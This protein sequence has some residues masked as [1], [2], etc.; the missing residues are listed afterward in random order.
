MTDRE[1]PQ[2]GEYASPQEQAKARAR[3]GAEPGPPVTA[4]PPSSAA[5]PSSGNG[6]A[7]P[8]AGTVDRLLTVFLLAFGLVYLLSGTASYLDLAV[9]MEAVYAQFGI[10]DYTPQPQT[11]AIGIAIVAGQAVIW[12]VS[13]VWAYRRLRAGRMAWWVPVLGAVVT[14]VVSVILLGTLLLG[15]PAFLENVTRA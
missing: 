12:L 4:R 1:R 6:R 13:A 11:Q 14:F 15:D 10:G 8:L 3:S 7:R 9:A 5:A 2:Y